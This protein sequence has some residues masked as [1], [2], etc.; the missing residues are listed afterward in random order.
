[1]KVSSNLFLRIKQERERE[2]FCQRA[3]NNEGNIFF[4]LFCLLCVLYIENKA[5]SLKE[6]LLKCEDKYSKQNCGDINFYLFF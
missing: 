5:S 3:F 4:F 6:C 1:M 2:D